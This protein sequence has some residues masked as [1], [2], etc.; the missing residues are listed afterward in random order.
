MWCLLRWTPR[1]WLGLFL[2]CQALLH[3]GQ[4]LHR[5]DGVEIAVGPHYISTGR[6]HANC[7]ISRGDIVKVPIW[8]DGHGGSNGEV[9][10]LAHFNGPLALLNMIEKLK[11]SF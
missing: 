2:F 1:R 8:S 3:H 4:C 6:G 7:A 11:V 5:C 9:E 10:L